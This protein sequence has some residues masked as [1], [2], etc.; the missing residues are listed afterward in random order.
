M[1]AR[2]TSAYGYLAPIG[3]RLGIH[4]GKSS[5]NYR[6]PVGKLSDQGEVAAHGYDVA[7]QSRNEQ[8]AT[9]FQAGNAVLAS[10]ED[11]GDALL[12]KAAGLAEI[13]QGHFLGDELCGALL[14]FLPARGVEFL[15]LVI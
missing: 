6:F 14:D 5:Q 9:F 8:V 13:A 3:R 2:F 4:G 10:L 7:A 12:G 1:A 11:F 15:H